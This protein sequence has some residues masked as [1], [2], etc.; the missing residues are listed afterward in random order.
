MQLPNLKRNIS[1]LFLLHFA[2][3]I[4]TFAAI[5]YLTRV[6]GLEGWGKLVFVQITISYLCWV[7]NWGYYLGGTKSVA[8]SRSDSAKIN[9]IYS[10]I[11]TS[12]ILITILVSSIFVC[13]LFNSSLFRD[14][15]YLYL[16]GMLVVFGNAIM[17]LWF[18][19]GL[20]KIIEASAIQVFIKGLTLPLYL[21]F[22]V[23]VDDISLYFVING[24]VSIFVGV[25]MLIWIKVGLRVTYV[26]PSFKEV[27]A[28]TKDNIYLFMSTILA[29]INTSIVPYSLGIFIGD[30]A[31]G[32]FNIADR[33]RGAA[34]QILHP[35]SH[36]LFPRM[37][38]LMNNDISEAKLLL[39][40]SGKLLILLAFFLSLG[41]FVFAENIVYLVAGQGFIQATVL[42]KIL[43]IS[44]LIST[45]LSFV[46]YQIVVPAGLDSIYLRT[47]LIMTIF[48][49]ICAIPVLLLWGLIGSTVLV[50]SIEF[51]GLLL[52]LRLGYKKLN[53]R[54]QV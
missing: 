44:P 30:Q 13:I 25:A 18:L 17:P 12:Q 21:F 50:V 38:Y 37:G 19:N 45:A 34:V 40:K 1:G 8:A 32:L 42:L 11:L 20:E 7:T 6:L 26:L 28:V 33:M 14:D 48:T 27:I 52:L 54:F 22:I 39:L 23:S 43:S 53:L 3:F 36:G 47:I 35:I 5:P 24:C 4:L 46:I 10:S 2:S 9:K 51:A 31:L 49:L 16:S 29:N 15:L 41:L